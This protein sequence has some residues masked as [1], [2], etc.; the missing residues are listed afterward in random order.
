MSIAN[1][2]NEFPQAPFESIEEDSP[3]VITA[4]TLGTS[5]PGFE[6]YGQLTGLGEDPHAPSAQS[7]GQLPNVADPVPSQVLRPHGSSQF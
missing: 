6:A 3:R 5:Q 7:T 2:H 4:L 1:T